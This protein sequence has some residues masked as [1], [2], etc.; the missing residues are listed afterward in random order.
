MAKL[1]VPINSGG[2]TGP[3]ENKVYKKVGQTKIT[4]KQKIE[5]LKNWYYED[6]PEHLFDVPDWSAIPNGDDMVEIYIERTSVGDDRNLTVAYVT[7]DSLGMK[8]V[9]INTDTAT[10]FI[11]SGDFQNFEGNKWYSHTGN[12]SNATQVD[13]PQIEL[14]SNNVIT[15]IDG[16]PTGYETIFAGIYGT[17]QVLL[18][19]KFADVYR[20]IDENVD[21]TILK[22]KA[23]DNILTELKN[24]ETYEF[25]EDCNDFFDKYNIVSEEVDI[26]AIPEIEEETPSLNPGISMQSTPTREASVQ[27]DDL[28]VVEY[29][30]AFY[31]P[32]SNV[33]GKSTPEQRGIIVETSNNN[34]YFFIQGNSSW[35][36]TMPPNLILR[37][38]YVKNAD[39]LKL[40]LKGEQTLEQK[41]SEGI[42]DWNYQKGET[43]NKPLYNISNVF[44]TW[45]NLV[46]QNDLI[47]ANN[48]SISAE[49]IYV[50][51]GKFGVRYNAQRSS[52]TVNF[53][54]EWVD[55]ADN[56]T[57]YGCSIS[58]SASTFKN[59]T[60]QWVKGIIESGNN[61]PTFTPIATQEELPSFI[62]NAQYVSQGINPRIITSLI[63]DFSETIT[64]EEK[65]KDLKNWAYE[66]TE[67]TTDALKPV[68]DTV[69]VLQD[70]M[71]TF[72]NA[73]LF[74][75]V[76]NE[77][78]YSQNELEV[79]WTFS[80]GVI[81]VT[82]K[83][84]H[85]VEE[86]YDVY[87]NT[88]QE[89]NSQLV[90]SWET[91]QEPYDA[92]PGD[93]HVI[94]PITSEDNLPEIEVDETLIE[95]GYEDVF[96]LLYEQAKAIT[97]ISLKDKIESCLTLVRLSNITIL[98][99][100]ITES[101]SNSYASSPYLY[102]W[103]ITLE[104]DAFK[105]ALKVETIFDLDEV[106]PEN[107]CPFQDIDAENGTLTLYVKEK[108]DIVISRIDIFKNVK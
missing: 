82:W 20:A 90:S 89:E 99:T 11:Y 87:E 46:A 63:T 94:T 40:I 105:D 92:Q 25:K 97:T 86:Y 74:T 17:E 21:T 44:E 85:D 60:Y 54:I 56:E 106:L 1:T 27:L 5:D 32:A 88:I 91:Y 42:K 35:T 103:K 77:I 18:K 10:Y 48:S 52:G 64:L 70:N 13:T 12:P 96:P 31:Q 7:D 8:G 29:I 100:D 67:T 68:Y 28:E 59:P 61:Q 79:Y 26:Y 62:Y 43:Q 58:V 14:D 98:S 71:Q 24:L 65:I 34:T 73:G 78:L 41:L 93:L 80:S 47:P 83:I 84:P 15:D 81:T 75:N 33:G 72:G 6:T 36:E 22:N 9:A 50:E 69:A 104:D 57:I 45:V 38:E 3:L 53:F 16:E 19:D 101:N 23:Y 55:I 107:I 108:S 4:L 51:Y 37:E 95:S 30:Y 49:I 76:N 102:I 39:M 66:E 2:S